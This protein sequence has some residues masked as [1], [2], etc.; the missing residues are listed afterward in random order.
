M[1]PMK[2]VTWTSFEL[3]F[4]YISILLIS[5]VIVG[6]RY[7]RMVFGFHLLQALRLNLRMSTRRF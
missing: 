5:G 4:T 2:M 6:T 3:L 1:T 7:I